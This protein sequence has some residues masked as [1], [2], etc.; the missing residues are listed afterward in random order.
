MF[1][2]L[3]VMIQTRVLAADLS[4]IANPPAIKSELECAVKEYKVSVPYMEVFG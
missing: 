1:N 4:F 3:V 2:F